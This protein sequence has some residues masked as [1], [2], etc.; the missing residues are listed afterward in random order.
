M[1]YEELMAV[2]DDIASAVEKGKYEVS[3]EGMD[4]ISVC[5]A[6][7]GRTFYKV[8]S[9]DSPRYSTF[10]GSCTVEV[11]GHSFTCDWETGE[12]TSDLFGEIEDKYVLEDGTEVSYEELCDDIIAKV[13]ICDGACFG[14]YICPDDQ[15]YA[16]SCIHG[17]KIPEYYWEDDPDCPVDV[18][19]SNYIAPKDLGIGT[20]FFHRRKYYLVEGLD[21]MNDDMIHAVH[22]KDIPTDDGCFQTVLLKIKHCDN[23]K[24]KVLDCIETNDCYYATEQEVRT[25]SY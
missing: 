14:T 7:D 5:E 20:V 11:A 17:T 19:D 25:D 24:L 2:I 12:V 16:L 4:N 13:E 22:C 3:F 6:P 9:C 10:Y 21:H 8:C 15:I 1:T 23:G 18:Y